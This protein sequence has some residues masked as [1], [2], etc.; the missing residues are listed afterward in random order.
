[1]SMKFLSEEWAQAVM[2]AV[3]A[4][5]EF[6]KAAG[7]SQARLQQVIKT[8]DGETHYWTT[9][10]DGKLALTEIRKAD[11][12][13]TGAIPSDSEDLVNYPR[14]LAGVEVGLRVGDVLVRQAGVDAADDALLVH[15]RQPRAVRELVA[16]LH[17]GGLQRQPVRGALDSLIAPGG[18]HA[19][20]GLDHLV[21]GQAVIV[22]APDT[23]CRHAARRPRT[24]HHARGY[25]PRVRTKPS[26]TM[27][28]ATVVR[29]K[30][31]RTGASH[32]AP[33]EPI[34]K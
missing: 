18:D 16:L 22:A 19:S 3:N 17:A 10:E 26:I 14:S 33:I 20:R 5:D 28:V 9:V 21:L 11:Y 8:A 31:L 32:G 4:N 30:A 24:E 1:M 7:A 29:D 6:A 15:D 2:E 25:S 27:T 34:R 23:E 13:A 12:A